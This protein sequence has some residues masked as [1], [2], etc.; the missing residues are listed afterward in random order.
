MRF[1][2]QCA[3]D[4]RGA[5]IM[6]ALIMLV[7]MAFSFGILVLSKPLFETALAKRLGAWIIRHDTDW[8]MYAGIGVVLF[9]GGYLS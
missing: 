7:G 9:V 1:D 4:Y 5:S 6:S 2:L 3:V 8:R